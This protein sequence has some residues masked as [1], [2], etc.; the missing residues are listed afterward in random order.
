[1]ITASV[2]VFSIL[3]FPVFS[4]VYVSVDKGKRQIKTEI[5]V[6]GITVFKVKVLLRGINV[7]VYQTFKKP[8]KIKLFSADIVKKTRFKPK[9]FNI[10]SVRFLLIK[11]INGDF[12]EIYGFFLLQTAKET[13]FSAITARKPFIKLRGDIEVTENSDEL[14]LY[15]KTCIVTNIAVIIFNLIKTLTEKTVCYMKKTR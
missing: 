2:I 14:N 15:V 1:M 4:G 12:A 7:L 9:G 3:I 8:S 10:L 5:T 11:G 13:A 6:F